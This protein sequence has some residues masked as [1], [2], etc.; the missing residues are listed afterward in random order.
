MKPLEFDAG[1][2]S[3]LI[4]SLH[5][6]GGKGTDNRKQLKGWN[7]QLAQDSNRTDYPCYVLAP[8]TDR[9]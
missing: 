5:G 3:A 7:R 2:S 4:V 1:Q 9:L 6:G 8:Q